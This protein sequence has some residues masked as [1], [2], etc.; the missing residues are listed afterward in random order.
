MDA[1][2]FS[3]P[4]RDRSPK[5]SPRPS[6]ATATIRASSTTTATSPASTMCKHVVMEPRWQIHSSAGKT[7]STI[8]SSSR[9]SSRR[10]KPLKSGTATTTAWQMLCIT[11][12][13]IDALSSARRARRPWPL[14]TSLAKRSYRTSLRAS[15]GAS[16]CRRTK[17]SMACN[18]LVRSR[19]ATSCE[20]TSSASWASQYG[21]PS[22]ATPSTDDARS[23]GASSVSVGAGEAEG[24]AVA[25]AL[26]A[27]Q[28]ANKYEPSK[29]GAPTVVPLL[30]AWEERSTRPYRQVTR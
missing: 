29:G 1:L 25:S 18:L 6:V 28:S 22:S 30:P 5:K 27:H 14:P 8:A 11:S 3:W 13:R 17:R 7:S 26:S 24:G 21:S 19:P 4:K 2:H 9:A 23:S 16:R 12:E 20:A 15:G 10:S